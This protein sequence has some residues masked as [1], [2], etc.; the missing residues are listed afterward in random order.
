MK[1]RGVAEL[2]NRDDPAWPMVQGW[3]HEATH[4]VEVL[5]AC[6]PDRSKALVCTQVTTR[7]LL[8]AVIYETGGLLID[9]GWLRVLGSGHPRLLRTVPGWSWGRGVFEEAKPP[10]FLL[11]A[12]D[13][14]GGFYAMDGGTLGSTV[15]DIHYFGPDTMRWEPMDTGYTQFLHWCLTGNLQEYYENQR[16]DGW[17]EDVRVI[18]GDQGISIW[19]PLCVRDPPIGE[20]SRRPVPIAELY[21]LYVI[22]LAEQL[23]DVPD[24]AQVRFGLNNS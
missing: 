16:W 18:P 10:N 21:D 23:R 4:P 15:G 1:L 20:R 22:Y 17:Q 5:P 6:E 24:G 11:I 13:V 2:I 12:D 19:P 14:L 9:H 3:I 7:S 8:G